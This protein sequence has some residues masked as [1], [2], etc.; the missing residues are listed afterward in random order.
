MTAPQPADVQLPEHEHDTQHI[1]D[2]MDQLGIPL[3]ASA[4]VYTA[5]IQTVAYMDGARHNH[6]RFS[7]DSGDWSPCPEACP[8]YG[9]PIDWNPVVARMTPEQR[10]INDHENSIEVFRS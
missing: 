5:V 1:A 2:I 6:T 4:D 10:R 3:D 8:L 9:P 7:N